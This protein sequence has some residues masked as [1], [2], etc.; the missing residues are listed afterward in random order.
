MDT[1]VIFEPFL[2][3]YNLLATFSCYWTLLSSCHLLLVFGI[4]PQ[5]IV[6]CYHPLT[7]FSF[8]YLTLHMTTLYY[9]CLHLSKASLF[10][11]LCLSLPVMP[12]ELIFLYGCW[13]HICIS[14]LLRLNCLWVYNSQIVF[15]F[16][17]STSMYAHSVS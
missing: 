3:G 13:A 14:L 5:D 9:H 8:A 17:K 2:D 16:N 7:T 6:G 10:S 12:S 15:L 4:V 1:C 11:H